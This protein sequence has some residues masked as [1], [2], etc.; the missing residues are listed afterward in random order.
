VVDARSWCEF[1][2]SKTKNHWRSWASGICYLGEGSNRTG[3][4]ERE[5]SGWCD[6]KRQASEVTLRRRYTRTEARPI[7]RSPVAGAGFPKAIGRFRI[8]T[9]GQDCR[10]SG[11]NQ[12]SVK[13]CVYSGLGRSSQSQTDGAALA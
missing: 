8:E 10:E 1:A 6:S 2:R 11:K 12:K 9:G 5:R 4:E 3:E 7:G 13:S